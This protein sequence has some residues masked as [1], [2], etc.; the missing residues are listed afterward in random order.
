M[1]GELK[2]KKSVKNEGQIQYSDRENVSP[3][4]CLEFWKKER[5]LYLNGE[6]TKIKYVGVDAGIYINNHIK[7]LEASINRKS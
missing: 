7:A 6:E 5:Q 2:T 4:V 1:S 3:E